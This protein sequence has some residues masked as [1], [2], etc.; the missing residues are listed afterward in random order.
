MMQFAVSVRLL[1]ID[2]VIADIDDKYSDLSITQIMVAP[3]T[4]LTL[5]ILGN[6]SCFCCLLL[7]F[8]KIN[9]FQKIIAGTLSECQTH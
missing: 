4:C 2:H 6:F 5:C 7:A 9:F 3:T 8:F 1:K